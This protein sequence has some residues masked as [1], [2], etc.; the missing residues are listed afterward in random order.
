MAG[1]L[2]GELCALLSAFLG[3]LSALLVRTQSHLLPPA[4]MN[5][6]RCGAAGLCYL[7]LLPF[8][9]PLATLLQV[10]LREWALLLASLSIG[11]V[12]GDTLY[13]T[14]IREI[15]VARA[16]ALA[17]T[18]PLLTMFFEWVLLGKPASPGLALG[19]GLVAGGVM[20]L[21]SRGAPA[22]PA[23]VGQPRSPLRLKYG[24]AMAL[25]AA[26]SWGLSMVFLGP[27]IAHLTT[28]QANAVRLPL[29]AGLLYFTRV[30]HRRHQDLQGLDRRA[31]LVVALSG[32][33]GMGLSAFTF[34][35]A[36]RMIGATKTAT[37]GST[38]PVFGVILAAFFLK[39]EVS[40]R[41]LL[42]IAACMGGVW[43]V[44]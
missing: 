26:A 25:G 5:A 12:V 41:M 21:S 42:G 23:V 35:S 40:L 29:V 1:A 20:L 16:L 28:I 17:C 3:A 44:L 19:A 30:H 13:L 27:A 6:L 38:S 18:C 22:E 10:P 2:S 34:L 37:L 31:G 43:L 15:G 11:M 8:T 7:V 39:E 14:A 24:A 9:E 32:L 36:L 33:V 4:A